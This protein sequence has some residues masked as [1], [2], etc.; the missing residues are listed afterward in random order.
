MS[1]YCQ[2]CGKELK[3]GAKF[4]QH[5]GNKIQ[6]EKQ[7]PKATKAQA[8]STS[9][10]TQ[11]PSP[12]P[13]PVAPQPVTPQPVTPQPATQQ[14]GAAPM[15]PKKSKTGLIIAIVAIVA[16]VVVLLIVIF[17]FLDGG[18]ILGGDEAKFYG[19]WEY[20][21]GFSIVD[22]T[23]HKNNTYEFS[24][25]FIVETGTWEI[26][27]SKLVIESD[28]IGPGFMSGNYEYEFSNND[29]TVTLS[30]IGIEVYEL[31]KK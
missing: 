22:F 13:E 30:F 18:G 20:D 26:K 11:Q 4:C 10:T 12:T 14:P 5:C 2:F 24:A 25:G 15:Q 23:F 17:L 16:V 28:M 8:K 27:N 31:T 1:K 3:K 6:I 29:N 21:S 9:Q 7:K 19:D